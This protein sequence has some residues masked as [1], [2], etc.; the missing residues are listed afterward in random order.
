MSLMNTVHPLQSDQQ[1]LVRCSS[2]S[3]RVVAT[4]AGNATNAVT[5]T[6]NSLSNMTRIVSAAWDAQL[7]PVA[8]GILCMRKLSLG[9]VTKQQ[10]FVTLVSQVGFS[11]NAQILQKYYEHTFASGILSALEAAE[12]VPL[13]LESCCSSVL[14]RLT[15]LFARFSQKRVREFAETYV[16]EH[17]LRNPKL[18]SAAATATATASN[19]NGTDRAMVLKCWVDALFQVAMLLLRLS[20]ASENQGMSVHEQQRI[21]SLVKSV[22][23]VRD[24]LV[25][26]LRISGVSSPLADA[27]RQGRARFAAAGVEIHSVFTQNPVNEFVPLLDGMLAAAGCP[28]PSASPALSQGDSPVRLLS[29]AMQS[30][31][32]SSSSGSLHSSHSSSNPLHSSSALS[33]ITATVLPAPSAPSGRKFVLYHERR[34]WETLTVLVSKPQSQKSL[35]EFLIRKLCAQDGLSLSQAFA[36]VT[37]DLILL[38][39]IG[40]SNTLSTMK[41]AGTLPGRFDAVFL[42]SLPF[43][44]CVFFMTVVV[45]IFSKLHF[46]PSA[47]KEQSFLIQVS[48]DVMSMLSH[49]DAQNLATELGV[50]D[51]QVRVFSALCVAGEYCGLDRYHI[52]QVFGF[53]D[54]SSLRERSLPAPPGFSSLDEAL[55]H[56]T[57]VSQPYDPKL[58]EIASFALQSDILD[59]MVFHHRIMRLINRVCIDHTHLLRMC[60]LCIEISRRE[61]VLEAL[62]AGNSLEPIISSLLC[63]AYV[64]A[65]NEV[66]SSMSHVTFGYCM[67]CLNTLIEAK[68][69]F[70]TA[71]GQA[72]TFRQVLGRSVQSVRSSLFQ[73]NDAVVHFFKSIEVAVLVCAGFVHDVAAEY[74]VLM[75][76]AQELWEVVS[77]TAETRPLPT[78]ISPLQLVVL[79]PYFLSKCLENVY[80]QIGSTPDRTQL[81]QQNFLF[82]MGPFIAMAPGAT[83]GAMQ[84]LKWLIGNY[85]RFQRSDQRTDQQRMLVVLHWA[86]NRMR[87]VRAFSPATEQPVILTTLQTPPILRVSQFV[88]LVLRLRSLPIVDGKTAA[89]AKLPLPAPF[90]Y[91]M[92]VLRFLDCCTDSS[93]RLGSVNSLVKALSFITQCSSSTNAD[94][95]RRLICDVTGLITAPN[96]ADHLGTAI[97]RLVRSTL[98]CSSTATV[99]RNS[100]NL[101]SFLEALMSSGVMTASVEAACTAIVSKLEDV[102]ET[103]SFSSFVPCIA[104]SLK[105]FTASLQSNLLHGQLYD[106]ALLKSAFADNSQLLATTSMQAMDLLIDSTGPIHG[107]NQS[108]MESAAETMQESAG[109][110]ESMVDSLS[111]AV[112]P[113]SDFMMTDDMVVPL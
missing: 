46:T 52:G 13:V 34:L 80:R 27:I 15:L 26:V 81:Q 20:A 99:S 96:V 8:F 41:N 74:V 82:P 53:M 38:Q 30:N 102:P 45:H 93:M 11:E 22:L 56:M 104:K 33:P 112:F 73:G 55:E 89:K 28:S 61:V 9:E 97:P 4:A 43:R 36:S 16:R 2:S 12:W 49:H 86:W 31:S 23:S 87:E 7:S 79:L 94:L 25:S 95:E 78:V 100:K 32:S 44:C 14:D 113:E 110:V 40:S 57:S 6:G 21:S 48:H 24:P 98:R 5:S 65:F 109:T 50:Q 42:E 106:E 72:T 51:M 68:V 54:D 1:P 10:L 35:L 59:S 47:R 103:A 88:Q 29:M 17:T 60:H 67:I 83:L 111:G 66:Q 91:L 108:G 84:H 71:A 3:Q 92:S 76:N 75:E 19:G 70:L 63:G 105:G 69:K 77:S 107:T 90:S 39:G 101:V 64:S 18:Q 58:S 85:G 62:D 37:L